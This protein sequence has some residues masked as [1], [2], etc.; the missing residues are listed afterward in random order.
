MCNVAIY[1]NAEKDDGLYGWTNQ[2]RVQKPSITIS[3]RGT[4]GYVSLR[5]EPFFPIVRL[6]VITPKPTISINYLYYALKEKHINGN[7]ANIPQL[8][9][10]MVKNI[11]IPLPP[12]QTQ[13]KIVA[14]FKNLESEISKREQRLA[15]LQGAYAQILERHL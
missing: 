15:N 13:Q 2:A 12:L 3:A 5:N 9:V 4:I 10:P 11:K 8:T 1:A 14:E 7:G 6:I